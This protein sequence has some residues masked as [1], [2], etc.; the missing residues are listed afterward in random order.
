MRSETGIDRDLPPND[1]RV[2]GGRRRIGEE[3]WAFN[4]TLKHWLF[5]QPMRNQDKKLGYLRIPR[6]SVSL[7]PP[8]PC[9]SHVGARPSR[10][11]PHSRARSAQQDYRCPLLRI[12]LQHGPLWLCFLPLVFVSPL[13]PTNSPNLRNLHLFYRLP[14]RPILAQNSGESRARKVLRHC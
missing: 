7:E 12:Y 6:S 11:S 13:W 10:P 8:P 2:S 3:L 4:V 14:Q 5:D 9:L 1:S